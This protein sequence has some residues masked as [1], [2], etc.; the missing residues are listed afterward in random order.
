MKT[1]SVTTGHVASGTELSA[2]QI[3]RSGQGARDGLFIVGVQQSY[4]NVL[5]APNY[6]P[7]Q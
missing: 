5:K 1:M 4:Y 6:L 7:H 3:A 2:N